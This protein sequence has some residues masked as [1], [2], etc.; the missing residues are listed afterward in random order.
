[1]GHKIRKAMAARDAY[2]QLAALLGMDD[3][4][5]ELSKPG[6]RG[7]GAEGKS[8]VVVAVE[9]RGEKPRFAKMR[10]VPAVSGPDIVSNWED[11]P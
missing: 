6:K 5:V 2:Y 10:P 8:K 9:T 4:Y 1:M 7:R 3:A 11:C